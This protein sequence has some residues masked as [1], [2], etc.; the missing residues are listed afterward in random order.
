ERAMALQPQSADALVNRG[1]ILQSTGRYA[2]AMRDYAQ[3]L[4]I[5]PQHAGAN[6]NRALLLLLQGDYA[7]GWAAY[8][9]RWQEHGV[10]LPW[11]SLPQPRWLGEG[12]IA[13]KTLLLHA[14]QGLGDTIQFCR[15]I[16]LLEARGARVLVA[17]PPT[18]AAIVA[19][20]SSTATVLEPGKALPDFD[21][22]CPM[23]SLP[24]ACRTTLEAVP[25]TIPYI[26][27][28]PAL[29]A[30]WC[31]K[32]GS[33]SKRR[34]GLVW[35]GGEGHKQDRQRSMA[36]ARLLPL[37]EIDVEFHSLQQAV[38]ASDDVALQASSVIRH[39]AELTS[40]AD[41]AALVAEMDLIISVDTSV[42]HLA[43]ALGVPTWILLAF[44]PDFRWMLERSDTPWY[45]TARLFRQPA[46]DD[47]ESVIEAARNALADAG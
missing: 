39:E 21:L 9:W 47:W 20:V 29:R 30:A 14:E 2:E 27:A 43:G 1:H 7:A 16:P 8:E 17:A 3:A 34:I 22:H 26:T 37:L 6:W 28:D 15:Y 19:S 46:L 13:G 32:L 35:S 18:L 31:A 11:M 24:L 42:A 33:R 44:T 36:F 45:P 40:F 38:R 23:G 41:T 10:A 25:A 4:A 12:D 5:A